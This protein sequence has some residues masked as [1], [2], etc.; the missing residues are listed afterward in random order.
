ME[1]ASGCDGF[2][3]WATL[4]DPEKPDSTPYG[5]GGRMSKNRIVRALAI[6]T[7]FAILTMITPAQTV[8]AHDTEDAHRSGGPRSTAIVGAWLVTTATGGKALHTYNADGTFNGS[9]QGE[10]ST[11]SPLGSHT[12]QHGVW[13]HLGGRRFAATYMDIFYDINTG[14]LKGFGNVSVLLTISRDGDSMSAEARIHIVDPAGNT[15]VDR[16]GTASSQR[17]KFAQPD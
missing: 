17:I 2:S 4:T 11:T 8:A 14:Q 10:I 12:L 15:L 9:V 13:R 3:S 5:T 16:A 7:T 1:D 6:A